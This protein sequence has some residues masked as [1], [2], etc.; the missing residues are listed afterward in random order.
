MVA[1]SYSQA[2]GALSTCTSGGICQ[3][4]CDA[5]YEDCTGGA[6]DGCETGVTSNVQNCGGCNIYCGGDASQTH[7]S[8][9]A[10]AA[11]TCSVTCTS[12]Y[13]PNLADPE[14]A[15]SVTTGTVQNCAS[16][17]DTCGGTNPFCDTAGSPT[18][19]Q[20]F[21]VE[22]TQQ[23][24]DVGTMSG[25]TRTITL[26][27]VA[28]AGQGRMLLVIVASTSTIT[29]ANLGAV[30]MPTLGASG[31][32]EGRPGVVA[33]YY[34]LDNALGSAGT[35]TITI[36]SEWGYNFVTVYELKYAEQSA[37]GWTATSSTTDCSGIPLNLQVRPTV[38]KAGSSIFA[39]VF[40]QSGTATAGAQIGGLA[41]T[42][43]TFNNNQGTGIHGNKVGVNADTTVGWAL[44]G[45]CWASALGVVLVKPLIVP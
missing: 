12:G 17:G 22:I 32:G 13:C 27:N 7:I 43:E 4:G 9:A 20:R 24:A 41:E 34:V 6:V 36:S 10:C 11:E 30:A 40:A 37:P 15:C 23:K 18:C 38:T 14:R 31:V 2:H 35:K 33:A 5:G 16:C 21:P 1:K 42:S 8:S 44:T 25:Q 26:D 45:G 28:A 29:A 3:L 19:R 39:G